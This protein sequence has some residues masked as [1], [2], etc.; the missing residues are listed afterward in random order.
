MNHIY[1]YS[2]TILYNTAK[3]TTNDYQVNNTGVIR[4]NAL[5]IHQSYILKEYPLYQKTLALILDT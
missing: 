1:R 2:P 5:K 4:H 3:Q